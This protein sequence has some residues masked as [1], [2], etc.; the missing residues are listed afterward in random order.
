MMNIQRRYGNKKCM[1]QI[2]CFLCML[3][4]LNVFISCVALSGNE[5]ILK[6][7]TDPAPSWLNEN[8]KINL[9]N[10][11]YIN[12]VFMK[13]DLYNLPL[14]LKQSQTIASVKISY[15]VLAEIQKQIMDK[16]EKKIK[17]DDKKTNPEAVAFSVSRAVNKCLADFK[18]TP[19]LAEQVYWEYRQPRL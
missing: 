11:N 18:I 5:T 15:L 16:I 4:Y 12:L 7:S 8:G 17:L 13:S 6:K 19:P 14:G 2:S 9:E 10:P 3:F 1:L